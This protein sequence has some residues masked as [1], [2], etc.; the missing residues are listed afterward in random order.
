MRPKESI[1][2]GRE[3]CKE[4]Q[5]KEPP[6]IGWGGEKGEELEEGLDLLLSIPSRSTKQSLDSSH[7]TLLFQ[8]GDRH[9]KDSGCQN[10]QDPNTKCRRPVLPC[11][12]VPGPVI[13]V[14]LLAPPPCHPKRTGHSRGFLQRA[15][16]TPRALIYE[17]PTVSFLPSLPSGLQA[18]GSQWPGPAEHLLL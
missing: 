8:M 12:L 5:G 11:W 14:S 13:L 16:R 4:K 15:G 9:R 7:V 2:A 17:F 6:R 3:V 10:V 1:F 18:G